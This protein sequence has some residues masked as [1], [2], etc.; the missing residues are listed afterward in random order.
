MLLVGKT[1]K[2]SMRDFQNPKIVNVT[3]QWIFIIYHV[4]NVTFFKCAAFL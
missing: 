1:L 4:S 3:N 2:I